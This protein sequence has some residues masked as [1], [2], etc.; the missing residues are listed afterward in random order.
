MG[1][2]PYRSSEKRGDFRGVP[3]I[4]CFMLCGGRDCSGR[5]ATTWA[6]RSRIKD[7]ILDQSQVWN[8]F[9]GVNHYLGRHRASCSVKYKRR[10]LISEPDPSPLLIRPVIKP[11]AGNYIVWVNH[12]TLVCIYINLTRLTICNRFCISTHVKHI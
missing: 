11:G 6:E 1:D 8:C 4:I 2:Y 9:R 10:G 12:P 5:L 3:Q 7:Q